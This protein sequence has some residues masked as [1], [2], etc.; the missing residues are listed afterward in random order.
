MSARRGALVLVVVLTGLGLML[1]L[2]ALRYRRPAAASSATVLALDVPGTLEEAPPT[3]DVFSPRFWRRPRLTLFD[4]VETIRGAAED[5]D[6]KGLVIHVDGIDWGWGKIADVRDALLEFRDRGKPIDVSFEGGGEPEYLLASAG[7][8]IAMPP[9][10]QLGL[11]GLSA[12]AVFLRGTFDKL[13]IR[14]NFLHVGRFKSAV[15]SYTRTDLS[16]PAR[17]AMTAMLGDTY[18][19]LVDS[20]A[21]SRRVARDS[22]RAWMNRGPFDADEARRLGLVDT[23]LYSTE[24]DSL[25]LRRAGHGAKLLRFNRYAQRYSPAR[26]GAHIAVVTAAG[27]IA[28]GRSR[29]D[30]MGNRVV[31]S[32]T[33][34]EA[35][36]QV[37]VRRSIRAVVLRIDS[38]GGDAQASDD[39]W[40]E[41]ERLRSVKPV[42]VSMSDLAAS[43]GYYIAV[44]ADSIV[45]QPTTITG[46][47]G[48]FGGKF[49]VLGLYHKLGLNVET[50]VTGPRAQMDSPFHDFN[51]EEE[52]ALG[53][54]L[55][56]SYRRFLSRVA[57]GRHLSVEAVDSIAQGRVW[58]GRAAADR[59]LVDEM[60][61]IEDAI[62]VARE[63]AGISPDAELVIDRFPE[64]ETSFL[65][66]F[67]G[68]LFNEDDSDDARERASIALPWRVLARAALLSQGS[69]MALMPFTLVIR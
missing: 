10:A 6:V 58:S 36:R 30:A 61:G 68:D 51:P 49:N 20:L 69:A 16:E 15:E 3:P 26:I 50:I 43:G 39:I 42:I 7:R 2:A 41:V 25:A 46:S 28:G 11:T 52:A 53:R 1:M 67:L 27:D 48:I 12:S 14:P 35:L 38:P 32:E 40:R 22:I 54:H 8:R 45:A 34:I 59:G 60:G 47:I 18:D 44:A 29:T 5:D 4:L 13:G 65:Q 55:E 56:Q 23:V 64:A 62:E 19:V 24:V 21:A 66:R 17:E 33:L 37:R 57:L 9:S 63:R 31:G